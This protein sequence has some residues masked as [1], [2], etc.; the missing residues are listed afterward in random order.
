MT[1]KRGPEVRLRPPPPPVREPMATIDLDPSESDGDTKAFSHASVNA[2]A[3]PPL[4]FRAS[5]VP[6]RSEEPASLPVFLPSAP[7]HVDSKASP[8][9]KPPSNPGLSPWAGLRARLSE[10]LMAPSSMG[11]L[12][13]DLLSCESPAVRPASKSESSLIAKPAR[14]PDLEFLACRKEFVP[15]IEGTWRALRDEPAASTASDQLRAAFEPGP[16]PASV[17]QAKKWCLRVMARGTAASAKDVGR[18]LRVSLGA[19]AEAS[20][21]LPLCLLSGELVLAFDEFETLKATV[22][23]VASQLAADENL[24]T[25]VAAA[26]PLLEDK[27]LQGSREAAVD[28]TACIRLACNQSSVIDDAVIGQRVERALIQSRAYSRRTLFAAKWVRCRVVHDGVAQAT[29]L[30]ES[31]AATLPLYAR[32]SARV[33]G[34]I[35]PRQDQDEESAAAICVVALGRLIEKDD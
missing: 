14:T 3:Q 27:T 35:H 30:T 20:P 10:P 33:I 29:Y 21:D 4:P 5:R 15:R 9:S 31:M 34:E 23:A 17:A 8:T 16:A 18:E 19:L 24:A 25:A 32:F 26:R 28:A 13:P 11:V 2:S 1:A 7:L 22:A 12:P 6:P